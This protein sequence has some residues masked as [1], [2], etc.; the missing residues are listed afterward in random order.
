MFFAYF[1]SLFKNVNF[2]CQSMDMPIYEGEMGG[3]KRDSR[4][5]ERGHD[6]EM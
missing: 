4:R 3:S 1:A 6:A 2:L 5:S